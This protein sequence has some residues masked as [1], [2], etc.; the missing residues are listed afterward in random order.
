MDRCRRVLAGK[1]YS[2]LVAT[3]Y[4][5]Y[6]TA[7]TLAESEVVSV[8]ARGE[9][10]RAIALGLHEAIVTRIAS[11]VRRLGPRER[12]L[13]AGGGALNACLRR[14]LGQKLGVD[15]TV[16][17]QPQIVGGLGA[18]LVARGSAVS[19]DIAIA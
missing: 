1:S 5:R 14:L 4:G 12:V 10:S 19:E 7:A 8:I 18:A 17:E 13:F 11:M 2:R 16:P 3:G 9:D 15:L 6:L